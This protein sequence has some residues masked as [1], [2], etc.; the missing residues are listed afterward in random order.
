MVGQ[1]SIL[2][3]VAVVE[4]AMLIVLPHGRQIVVLRGAVKIVVPG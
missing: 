3:H 4:A 2:H 1:G